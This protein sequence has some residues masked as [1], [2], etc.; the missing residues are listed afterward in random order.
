M[1]LQALYELAQREGLV[2]DPDFEWKPVRWLI[3][4]NASGEMTGPMRCT[5]G[6]DGN[7]HKFAVPRQPKRTVKVTPYFFCDNAQ[8]AFG[9]APPDKPDAKADRVRRCFQAFQEQ[10]SQCA[11]KTLDPGALAVEAF[12]ARVERDGAPPLPEALKSNDQI[13]FVLTA[14]LDRLVTD[15]PAIQDYWRALRS[16][17]T[18]A[19]LRTCLV[20]GQ[21]APPSGVHPAVKK[22]PGSNPAGCALISFNKPAFWSYNWSEHEN[23]WLS[24]KASE[25]FSSALNR[26]LDPA[27]PDPSQ[28][29]LTLPR[30]NLRLTSDTAVCFWASDNAADPL[31]NSFEDLFGANPEKVAEAYRSLWGGRQRPLVAHRVSTR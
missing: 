13:A 31:L 23:A 28:P 3:S 20:S 1:I 16:A 21:S 6:E 27:P 7:P 25:G 26:L 30:R 9:T 15:R 22:L 10:V 29:G 2:D 4:V 5:D 17:D 12:L 14:D 24:R 11:Q 8:Y 19:E 18:G